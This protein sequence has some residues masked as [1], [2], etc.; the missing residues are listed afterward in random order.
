M[1]ITIETLAITIETLYTEMKA[2]FNRLNRMRESLDRIESK[3]EVFES[4]MAT[5]SDINGLKD[6]IIKNHIEISDDK[7]NSRKEL[8]EVRSSVSRVDSEGTPR[9][10]FL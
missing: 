8:E 6:L 4:N 7:T 9:T 5:K 2:G 1:A 3:M 10:Y